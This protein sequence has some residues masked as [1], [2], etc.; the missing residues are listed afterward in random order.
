MY[1]FGNYFL[2]SKFNDDNNLMSLNA[3]QENGCTTVEL[4]NSI[5]HAAFDIKQ[6]NNSF[7]FT[8]RMNW[9]KRV[10][11]KSIKEIDWL[12]GWTIS[13]WTVRIGLLDGNFTTAHLLVIGPFSE[14]IQWCRIK[15]KFHCKWKRDRTTTHY[16]LHTAHCSLFRKLNGFPFVDRD[17]W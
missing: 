4:A 16:P 2:C 5:M 10:K 8:K 12:N 9:Q 17:T 13:T 11:K 6:I 15:N 7:P 14:S 3:V 1:Q